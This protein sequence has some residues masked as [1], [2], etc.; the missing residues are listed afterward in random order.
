MGNDFEKIDIY[1]AHLPENIRESLKLFYTI[2]IKFNTRLNLISQSTE[3]AAAKNHFA[4]SVLGVESL[5]AHKQP[6]GVVYDFGSG[7]GFPGIIFALLNP[8]C[9]V[10]LV[11]KDQRKCEF[12][13]YVISELKLENA[14][15]FPSVLERL[16]ENSITFGIT[17]AMGDLSRVLIQC[18]PKFTEG[19]VLY[20]FK[21]DN[22]TTELAQCPTQIFTKWDIQSLDEYILPDSTIKRTI[23]A[24]TAL[25]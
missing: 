3:T 22:W 25:K 5:C 8:E 20:H 15:T 24:A 6:T 4:D 21:T 19:G 9:Q 16:E 10:V 17:R 1:M 12:M 14:Q 11:E 13:K 7:N 2:L 23:V 18:G